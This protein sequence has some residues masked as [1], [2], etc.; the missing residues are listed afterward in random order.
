MENTYKI[1]KIE[2]KATDWLDENGG[3]CSEIESFGFKIQLGKYEKYWEWM[4]SRNGYTFI[5]GG[6]AKTKDL[7]KEECEK[8]WKNYLEQFLDVVM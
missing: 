3:Y 5:R 1:K 8:A 4:I 6:S 7:A 2:W